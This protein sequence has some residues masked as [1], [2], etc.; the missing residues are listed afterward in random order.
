[1]VAKTP[2]V[3]RS[4]LSR[5][6]DF[7]DGLSPEEEVAYRAI[8]PDV[9]YVHH[10][11]FDSP[12]A[13]EPLPAECDRP[14]DAPAW[15]YRPPRA[16]HAAPAGPATLRLSRDDE[17]RLFVQ[18]NYA[19]YRLA[20]LQAI[21]PAARTLDQI[22]AMLAWHRRAL[23]TCAVLVRANL[24]LVL[25]MVRRFGAQNVEASELVSEGNFVLLRCV[26][27][28]DAGRGFKFSTYACRAILK[29]FARLAA[30]VGRY[31]Q[32]FPVEF[33]PDLERSDHAECR[34][35][36]RRTSRIEALRE[37]LADNRAGLADVERTIVLERFGIGSRGERKTLAA[38]A[39]TVGCCPERVRQIQRLALDKLRA[40][41]EDQCAPV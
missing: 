15:P 28:F 22:R 16:E 30:K 13:R 29:G 39:R 41:L 4:R 20:K 23:D 10:E 35:Q 6:A 17:A 21:P 24:P 31:R 34:R 37:V 2:P 26:E 8:P 25:A 11:S 32:R 5:G 27:K 7:P 9:P 40:A 1:M 38:V 33:D 36:A 19:R 18:Y 14:P 12:S 3:D